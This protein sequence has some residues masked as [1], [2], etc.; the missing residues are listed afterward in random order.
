MVSS[1]EILG[2]DFLHQQNVV[3]DLASKRLHLKE[4]ESAISLGDLK[5]HRDYPTYP[6]VCATTTVEVPPRSCLEV[7]GT[8]EM[9]VDGVWVLE[10]RCQ[11]Y[12]VA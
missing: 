4:D 11:P 10:G 8:L 12:A 3:I 6:Q 7:T 9:A 1:E 5:Q 2:L